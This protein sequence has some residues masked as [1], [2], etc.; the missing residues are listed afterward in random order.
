MDIFGEA[1]SEREWQK[2]Y[3]SMLHVVAGVSSWEQMTLIG[4]FGDDSLSLPGIVVSL[5]LDRVPRSKSQFIHTVVS[6]PGT[7]RHVNED[8]MRRILKAIGHKRNPYHDETYD[9]DVPITHL[10]WPYPLDDQ[11]SHTYLRQDLQ[12]KERV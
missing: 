6:R 12:V 5:S 4:V 8:E 9:T 3:H 1:K 7:S 10:Y 11:N 2:L